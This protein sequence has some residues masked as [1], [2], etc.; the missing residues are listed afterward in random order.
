MAVAPVTSATSAPRSVAEA[1][2]AA[3]TDAPA[4]A[5]NSTTKSAASGFGDLGADAFLKLLVAQMRYQN[6]FSPSDPTAMMGQIAQFTQV[7]ALNKVVT[8]SQ[9]AYAMNETNFASS[10]IGRQVSLVE[11]GASAGTVES[12]R[13]TAAGPVLKFNDGTEAPLNKVTTVMAAPKA[14]TAA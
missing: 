7:E 3:S 8:A 12:V 2:A 4:A 5:T 14:P 1:A 9:T 13:F 10:L 6:P 11:S